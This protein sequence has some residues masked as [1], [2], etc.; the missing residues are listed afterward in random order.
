[1]LSSKWCRQYTATQADEP[2]RESKNYPKQTTSANWEPGSLWIMS[3][4]KAHRITFCLACLRLR[5]C[6]GSMSHIAY[7]ALV[8]TTA[9]AVLACCEMGVDVIW[10]GKQSHV[11]NQKLNNY[12]VQE[13][14]DIWQVTRQLF[15]GKKTQQEERNWS[16]K[17]PTKL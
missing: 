15:P 4:M 13:A 11:S 6:D 12:I 3:C 16:S 8:R 14:Q 5:L 7:V 10:H 9:S 2:R 17:K 1:M